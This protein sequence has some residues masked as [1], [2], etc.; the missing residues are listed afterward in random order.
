MTCNG[1]YYHQKIVI[2]DVTFYIIIDIDECIS[3]D[4]CRANEV[5]TNTQG[6]FTCTCQPGYVNN[7]KKCTGK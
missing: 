2:A 5:C 4:I 3:T 7:G 6:S 1:K